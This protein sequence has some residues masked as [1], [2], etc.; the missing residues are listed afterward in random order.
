[1]TNKDSNK[2]RL[3]LAPSPTGFLHLGNFRTA[4]FTYLLAKKWGG[5]FILRIED[6]D[7]KREVEGAVQKLLSVL[8]TLGLEFDEGPHI[9]GPFA[10]YI[11]SERISLYQ[12]YAHELVEKGVA[13]YCFTTAGE[14]QE[15][16]DQQAAAHKPPR[17]DRRYRDLPL[18]TAKERV[19][20]GEKYV[21]R[22]A[23]PLE[24]NITVVDELRG[25]ITFAA[26]ELEDHVLLKSD[27]GATY[28]L[29]S[30]IDDHLMGITHVT[31]GDEWLPSLPKNILLY[32]AFGWTPPKFFHLPLILNKQGGG[33][34]SKR[35]GDVFVEDFL[36]KGYTKEALINFSVLLGWHP[37]NDQEIFSLEELKKTFDSNGIGTSPAIFD[38]EKLDYF[39]AHYLRL[40]SLNELLLLAKPF[41][42][43]LLVSTTQEKKSDDFLL[44]IL[45]LEQPRLKNLIELQENTKFFFESSL[46]L[47]P[48]LLIWKKLSPA[49]VKNNLLE[50]EKYLQNLSTDWHAKD[51]EIKTVAYLKENNKPLGDYLWPLRVALSGQKTSPSP[52]EIASVLGKEETL[53]KIIQAAS[54]LS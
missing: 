8:K 43:P 39:N 4:L 38:P 29:A 30:V 19:A 15:M 44:K 53:A 42:T 35:Q 37:K 46:K 18:V 1:M 2:P 16:R 49:E 41:F 31:R 17:Y 51:L 33:K 26:T 22:Q 27:G 9:G 47:D 34:L 48:S 50:I 52:F 10:P 13:Y 7:E 36:A 5:D 11:Q 6:T 21:I 20:N 54:L 3:R 24:G 23:M 12:Q 40:K 28:Q 25:E 45:K 14:L 32:Q